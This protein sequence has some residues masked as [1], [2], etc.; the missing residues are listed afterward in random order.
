MN[1]S[2]SDLTPDCNEFALKLVKIIRHELRVK[3]TSIK[4]Y[5]SIIEFAGPLTDKQKE[6]LEKA[7]KSVDEAQEILDGIHEEVKMDV[8]I[9][10]MK[11]EERV[12]T[13]DLYT[14]VDEAAVALEPEDDSTKLNVLRILL[15]DLP[16]VQVG[17]QEL[18]IVLKGLLNTVR[19]ASSGDVI[20]TAEE[21]ERFVKVTISS[22]SSYST[23]RDEP[24]IRE[25]T[26]S[27]GRVGEWMNTGL[28]SPSYSKKL[29]EDWG[30]EIGYFENGEEINGFWFTL[31]VVEK[32][33]V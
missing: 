12:D 4:G 27:I 7:L 14:C 25:S 23:T 32:D 9:Q 11:L 18:F 17:K 31:P 26:K 6:F 24:S 21:T 10:S 29:V 1:V 2:D 20:L 22:D 30:G 13:L 3:F 16:L 28:F 15:P 19:Y 5:S 33:G 8:R